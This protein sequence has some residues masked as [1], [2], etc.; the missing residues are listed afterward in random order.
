MKV[1]LAFTI[2]VAF[3][4]FSYAEECDFIQ[5]VNYAGA[6]VASYNNVA[7]YR[8]CCLLCQS[9]LNC[10]AWSWDGFAGCSLRNNTGIKLKSYYYGCML[11][12]RKTFLYQTDSKNFCF[13]IRILTRVILWF[14]FRCHTRVISR[15]FMLFSIK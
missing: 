3:A 2:L 5:G 1:F 15:Y 14:S 13:F 11:R 8:D 6:E 12:F 10:T 9:N 7:N 4:T